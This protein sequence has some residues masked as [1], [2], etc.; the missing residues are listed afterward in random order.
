MCVYT[1]AVCVRGRVLDSDEGKCVFHGIQCTSNIK[2]QLNLGFQSLINLPVFSDLF[3]DLNVHKDSK[4]HI[5]KLG[6]ICLL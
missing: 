6:K 3:S 1:H 5:P 2:S 4:Q